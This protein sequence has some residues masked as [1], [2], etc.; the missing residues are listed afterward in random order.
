MQF[1]QLGTDFCMRAESLII[2]KPNATVEVAMS[3]H[4]QELVQG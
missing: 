3:V 4:D 2:R 1:A